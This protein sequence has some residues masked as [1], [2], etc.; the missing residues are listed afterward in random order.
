MCPEGDFFNDNSWTTIIPI[1][2]GCEAIPL[3][4]IP[5]G[6]HWCHLMCCEQRAPVVRVLW[7]NA[8]HNPY[9]QKLS[10][11]AALQYLYSK[12]TDSTEGK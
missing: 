6:V 1:P 11:C 8:M 12:C 4:E 9:L 3:N 10:E 2:C 5:V 7:L